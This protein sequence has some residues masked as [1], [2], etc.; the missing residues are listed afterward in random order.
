MVRRNDKL[1]LLIDA[2]V[3]FGSFDRRRHFFTSPWFLGVTN[4]IFVVLAVLVTYEQSQPSI[5][6][7]LCGVRYLQQPADSAHNLVQTQAILLLV[8]VIFVPTLIF[9]FISL[10][11]L[12]CSHFCISQAVVFGPLG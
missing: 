6:A 1:G 12:S 8:A 5:L 4:F 3:C 10:V 7:K 9:T 2:N 11:P